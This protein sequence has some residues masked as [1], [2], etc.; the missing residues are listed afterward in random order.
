MLN[1]RTHFLCCLV[2]V[3]RVYWATGNLL[4][5][6]S[7]TTVFAIPLSVVL[8]AVS[9]CI[10]PYKQTYRRKICPRKQPE[11]ARTVL[12]HNFRSICVSWAIFVYV[13][14]FPLIV[15]GFFKV[16][17]FV[18][19]KYYSILERTSETMFLNPFPQTTH[20]AS[21]AVP[22]LVRVAACCL[23]ED[24]ICFAHQYESGVLNYFNQPQTLPL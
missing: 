23:N 2:T 17:N 1:L 6:H 24:Y 7:A 8:A 3:K 16:W 14:G 22:T 13:T 11:V 10:F 12:Q 15:L 5:F 19:K 9:K 4:L 21:S 18:L 20:Y